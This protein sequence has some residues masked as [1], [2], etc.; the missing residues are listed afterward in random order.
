MHLRNSC[1]RSTSACCMRQVPSGASGARGVNCVICLLGAVIPRDVGHEVLHHRE[2]AH[3]LDGDRLV[4]R[5]VVEPRHAHQPRLAVDLRGAR[6]A[7][8]GLAV[9]T[10]GEVV[11]LS[12]PGSGGWRRAPPC[13]GATRWSSRES[14]PPAALPRQIRNVAMRPVS[15]PAAG[16]F[17]A[18][19]EAGLPVIPSP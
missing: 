5:Q 4:E 3:R 14:A 1:T 11:G 2:G 8:A 7:L 12:R 9:P 16:A 17:V 18:A 13:P 10:H 6:A 15:S 19:A